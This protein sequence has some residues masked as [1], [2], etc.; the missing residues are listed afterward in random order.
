VTLSAVAEAYLT[1]HSACQNCDEAVNDQMT[2]AWV[3]TLTGLY[4]CTPGADRLVGGDGFAAPYNPADREQE[5][6]DQYDEGW[7]AGQNECEEVTHDDIA[8][9]ARTAGHD[10]GYAEGEAE[11]KRL[12]VDYLNGVHRAAGAAG[13]PDDVREVLRELYEAVTG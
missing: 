8:S 4:R 10:E 9:D 13:L 3:H 5:L 2:G 1:S 6:Q 12:V 7:K 11:I